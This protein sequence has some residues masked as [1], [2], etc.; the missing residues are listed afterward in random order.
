MRA[1]ALAYLASTPAFITVDQKDYDLFLRDDGTS[2]I[3]DAQAFSM[4]SD[5]HYVVVSAGLVNF[6]SENLKRVRMTE[7]TIES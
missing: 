7:V 6:G 2:S 3:V 5:K 4:A 1:N